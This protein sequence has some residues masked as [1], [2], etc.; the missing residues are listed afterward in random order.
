[1][2]V[3]Q[4]NK[5]REVVIAILEK[6]DLFGEMAMVQNGI[7]SATVTAISQTRLIPV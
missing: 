7:R 5:G 2:N 4:Q 6:G 3:V 1:M